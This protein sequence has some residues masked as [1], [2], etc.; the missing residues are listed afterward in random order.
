MIVSAASLEGDRCVLR[1]TPMID[2][3]L[4]I[5]S[6]RLDEFWEALGRELT[7]SRAGADSAS[8]VPRVEFR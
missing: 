6:G 4:Y 3:T 2:R 1:A 7:L 8:A 5:H